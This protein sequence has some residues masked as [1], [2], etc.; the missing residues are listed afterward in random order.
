MIVAALAQARQGIRIASICQRLGISR[1]TFHR[2]RRRYDG[3]DLSALR[4]TRLLEEENRRLRIRAAD[5]RLTHLML[6]TLLKKR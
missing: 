6:Q 5:L 4:Q 3:L 2:W 1:A